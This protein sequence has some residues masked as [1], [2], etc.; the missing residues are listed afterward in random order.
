MGPKLCD[1][2]YL[3]NSCQYIKTNKE[4]DRDEGLIKLI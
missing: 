4:T 3:P 2:G 1:T